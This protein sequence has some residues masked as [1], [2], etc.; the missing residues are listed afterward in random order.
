MRFDTVFIF[1]GQS[2]L[3]LVELKYEFMHYEYMCASSMSGLKIFRHWA[4]YFNTAQVKFSF[5]SKLGSLIYTYKD[6]VKT[7]TS[8]Y[9]ASKQTVF[10]R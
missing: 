5:L 10:G 8:R 1:G 3:R 7:E 9:F 2:I 6:L 4:V